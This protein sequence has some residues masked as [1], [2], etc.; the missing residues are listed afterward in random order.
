MYKEA[1]TDFLAARVVVNG[2]GTCKYRS[3]KGYIAS[4]GAHVQISYGAGE[5]KR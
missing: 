2:T 4:F 1:W 5:A 3:K